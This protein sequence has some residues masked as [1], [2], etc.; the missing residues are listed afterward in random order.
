MYFP[1]FENFAVNY[2]GTNSV[3][4]FAENYFESTAIG[5]SHRDLRPLKSDNFKPGRH[6]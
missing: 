2:T 3:V 4:T 6:R 1:Y 5:V